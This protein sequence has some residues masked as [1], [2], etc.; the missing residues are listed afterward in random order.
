MTSFLMWNTKCK[1]SNVKKRTQRPHKCGIPLEQYIFQVFWSHYSLKVLTFPRSDSWESIEKKHCPICKCNQMNHSLFMKPV[2]I[3]HL[4]IRLIRFSSSVN[5]EIHFC[6]SFRHKVLFSDDFED[7]AWVLWTT[8]LIFC[9]SANACHCDMKH[10]FTKLE[11]SIFK[12]CKSYQKQ[13]FS[14]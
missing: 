6:V 3:I 13:I 14:I 12:L 8:F 7:T 2:W 4:Q 10:V 1:L 9:Y 5:N 11:V